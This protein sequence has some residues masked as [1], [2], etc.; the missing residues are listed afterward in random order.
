VSDITIQ[1]QKDGGDPKKVT[2][3]ADAVKA[4]ELMPE[5]IEVFKLADVD[6]NRVLQDWRLSDKTTG[7]LL[8]LE[9]TLAEN[10]VRSGDQLRIHIK[11]P[12][13]SETQT[14]TPSQP[15][16]DL[17]ICPHCGSKND[18]GN[19]FCRECGKLMSSSKPSADL[20][21]RVQVEDGAT[22]E[23]TIPPDFRD[24][25][26]IAQLLGS[27]AQISEWKL[28]DKST[29]RDLDPTKSLAE[30][31]VLSGH[32]LFLQKRQPVIEPSP[33]PVPFPDPSEGDNGF[34]WKKV[35]IAL[36]VVAIAIVLAIV[37]W[38]KPQPETIV[39]VKVSPPILTMVAGKQ[40]RFTAFVT[41]TSNTTVSW[42][43]RGPGIL[44]SD[45]T[46][47]SPSFIPTDETAQ[48]TATSAADPNKK[49]TAGV[50]LIPTPEHPTGPAHPSAQVHPVASGFTGRWSVQADAKQYV[51]LV[52][53]G[54]TV[55]LKWSVS[56]STGSNQGLAVSNKPCRLQIYGEQEVPVFP[57]PCVFWQ[58]TLNNWCAICLRDSNQLDFWYASSVT[59]GSSRITHLIRE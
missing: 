42:S 35:G 37:L 18:A 26:L 44:S 50:H 52:Q 39:V 4:A 3:P 38:P 24:R 46:Y 10:G 34:P 11:E 40:F 51:D 15:K 54:T 27:T 58:T 36:G 43:L 6:G 14:E 23:V 17:L 41:G 45:G 31:G 21:V 5:L 57:A 48:I 28:T 33:Q 25:D 30:N 1:I 2:L 29:G 8:D 32:E 16:Q 12:E 19:K 59:P 22:Q 49:A 13:N 47:Q 56:G 55:S 9:R 20:R 53:N 7:R